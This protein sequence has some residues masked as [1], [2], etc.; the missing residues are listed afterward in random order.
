MNRPP[1]AK[2][3]TKLIR[4]NRN[5]GWNKLLRRRVY[6][7]RQCIYRKMIRKN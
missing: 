2:E 1:I 6:A 5:N 4:F 3:A 7:N